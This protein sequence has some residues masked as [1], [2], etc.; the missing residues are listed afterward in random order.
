MVR[1]AHLG[2]FITWIVFDLV[3]RSVACLCS[4]V[5][6]PGHLPVALLSG[7]ASQLRSEKELDDLFL[8]AAI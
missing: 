7:L 4:P 5:F 8:A 3:P 6:R 2:L 1:Q